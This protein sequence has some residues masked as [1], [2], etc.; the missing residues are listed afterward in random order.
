MYLYFIT[1]L[2]LQVSEVSLTFELEGDSVPEVRRVVE[3]CSP[4]LRGVRFSR[5]LES[6]KW[7]SRKGEVEKG[8]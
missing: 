7:G 2:V 1:S 3:H 8:K 4:T 6:R 5:K